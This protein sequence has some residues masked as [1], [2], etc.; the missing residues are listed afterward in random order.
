MIIHLCS[1]KP[2]LS[3]DLFQRQYEAAAAS[4]WPVSLKGFTSEV[5]FWWWE[6]IFLIDLFIHKTISLKAQTWSLLRQLLS[7]TYTCVLSHSVV[8]NSLQPQ[9]L[10]PIRLL[11]PWDFPDKNT[12]LGCRFLLHLLHIKTPLSIYTIKIFCSQVK[13]NPYKVRCFPII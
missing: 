6:I 13:I 5:C 10:K 12:G 2:L 7:L 4:I 8:S 1:F 11:C 9:G 3:P